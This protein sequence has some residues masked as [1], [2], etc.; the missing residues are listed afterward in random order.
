[1]IFHSQ[2]YK[3]TDFHNHNWNKK[4]ASSH[5]EAA[6]LGKKY[7]IAAKLHRWIELCKFLGHF[8]NSR[9]SKRAKMI[10]FG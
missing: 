7:H 3:K 2:R 9:N 4:S 10:K 6:L 1:M 5:D 8:L